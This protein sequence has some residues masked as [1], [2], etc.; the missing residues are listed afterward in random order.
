MSPW[1]ECRIRRHRMLMAMRASRDPNT[2]SPF[3]RTR[4]STQPIHSA[5]FRVL[6]RRPSTLYSAI[7]RALASRTWQRPHPSEP[8][9]DGAG[10]AS[11]C[12]PSGTRCTSSRAAPGDWCA[13]RTPEWRLRIN[14]NRISAYRQWSLFTTLTHPSLDANGAKCDCPTR[15]P[16]YWANRSF[17][18]TPSLQQMTRIGSGSPA[19][20]TI[21]KF[22]FSFWRRCW[23]IRILSP[24][25]GKIWEKFDKNAHS[26]CILFGFL[27][28]LVQLFESLQ[29]LVHQDVGRVF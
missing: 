20:A 4:F 5:V 27:R 16:S 19:G 29:I 21:P 9:M 2:F 1:N 28:V 6:G 13:A 14:R 24:S 15:S 17:S 18:Q 3:G 11:H 10:P 25:N 26:V 8:A 23:R 12:K 22:R 7:V